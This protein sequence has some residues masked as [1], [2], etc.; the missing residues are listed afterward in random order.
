VAGKAGFD[1]PAAVPT[2]EI[3]IEDETGVRD[4][5]AGEIRFAAVAAGGL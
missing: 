1:T 5:I 4:A 2:G 3:D